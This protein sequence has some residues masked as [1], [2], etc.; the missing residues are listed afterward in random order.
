MEACNSTVGAAHGVV[1]TKTCKKCGVTKPLE[2]FYKDRGGRRAVCKPCFLAKKREYNREYRDKN[3]KY[4]REYN[5][6]YRA[7]NQEYFREHG[8]QWRAE[9]PEYQREYYAEN[10]G[11][12]LAHQRRYRAKNEEKTVAHT[13]VTLAIRAGSLVRP[14]R[15]SQCGKRC[16]PDAHHDDY[17]KPLDV[18]WICRACHKLHHGTEKG[19][20]SLRPPA[21]HHP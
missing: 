18:R 13:A 11:N 7:D 12:I 3:G 9:N 14:D 20:A 21:P 5:R 16:T 8:R 1:N 19:D 2:D 6:Q 10:R 17:S 15:C 4:L